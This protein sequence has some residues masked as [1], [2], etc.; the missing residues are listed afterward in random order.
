MPLESYFASQFSPKTG[1]PAKPF[2][3]A[4]GALHSQQ[5]LFSDAGLIQSLSQATLPGL[6]AWAEV[7]GIAPS[8]CSTALLPQP[9]ST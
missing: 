4:F 8:L 5:R 6:S 1:V 9:M 3:L 7:G 2:Q